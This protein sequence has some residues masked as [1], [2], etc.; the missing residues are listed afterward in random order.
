MRIACLFLPHFFVQVEKLSDPDLEGLPLVVERNGSI[1]DCAEEAEAMGIRRGMSAYEAS[2]LC[3]D[4]LF[5]PFDND[6]YDLTWTNLLLAVGGFSSSV[7]SEK[8]GTIYLDLRGTSGSREDERKKAD[9]LIEEICL[10]FGLK[11]RVG[12]ADSRFAAKEAAACA[13][14]ILIVEPGEEGEFL[15]LLS[16]K[17]LSPSKRAPQRTDLQG[18][19]VPGGLAVLSKKAP[20]SQFCG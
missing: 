14:D 19:P 12:V 1:V 8:P 6:R 10:S 7:K 20:V 2:C 11:A 4:A 3:P 5:L 17:T 9:A 15:S 16:P 13:W 18:S